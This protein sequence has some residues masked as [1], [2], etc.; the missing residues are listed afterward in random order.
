LKQ[1]ALNTYEYLLKLPA[2]SQQ[3]YFKC[4][5]CNKF[6]IAKPYLEKHYLK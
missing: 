5:H 2:A 3:D 4:N 1:K 6:F